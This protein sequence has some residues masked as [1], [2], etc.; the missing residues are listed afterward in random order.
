MSV[1]TWEVL[2]SFVRKCLFNFI[3]PCGEL[4]VL[5]KVLLVSRNY[6]SIHLEG[7]LYMDCMVLNDEQEG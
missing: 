6:R 4:P 3:G 1:K 7:V 2:E 5:R